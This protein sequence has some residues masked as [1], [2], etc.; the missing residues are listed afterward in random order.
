ERTAIGSA[1]WSEVVRD[2]TVVEVFR[3]VCDPGRTLVLGV[4]CACGIE[5]WQPDDEHTDWLKAPRDN[6]VSRRI[7]A[8]RPAVT[9]PRRR[10]TPMVEA[11]DTSVIRTAPEFAVSHIDDI[12]FPIDAVYTWVDGAD[13]HW[14]ARKAETL[15]RIGTQRDVNEFAAN[16]A[17]FVNRD[18]LRYSLRS[19]HM[20]APWIRHIYVI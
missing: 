18:E 17:R 5:F 2:S 14:Q 10:F 7:A 9:A 20:Y 19:L 12:T 16:A 15:G 3:T 4:D 8:D 11:S 6:V 1:R 13:S